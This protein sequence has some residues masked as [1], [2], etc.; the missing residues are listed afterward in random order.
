ML[1]IGDPQ[2]VVDSYLAHVAETAGET[3]TTRD[4]SP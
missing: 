1:E 4:P 2:K 3:L